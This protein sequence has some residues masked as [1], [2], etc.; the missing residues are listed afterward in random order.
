MHLIEYLKTVSQD[1]RNSDVPKLL[2]SGSSS[3]R[4]NIS[5]GKVKVF[6]SFKMCFPSQ[7]A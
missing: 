7:Y 6:P 3:F 4:A 2:L 5:I 1:I